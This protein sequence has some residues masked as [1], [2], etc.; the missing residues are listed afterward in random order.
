[1]KVFSVGARRA[2]VW[3]AVL[4]SAIL[5]IGSYRPAKAV[6]LEK[7]LGSWKGRGTAVFEG[8]KREAV[9]CNAYYT[10]G[11][12][13]LK[14]AVRCASTSYKIE[15]RSKLETN[16]SLVNGTWEERTFNAAGETTG[17]INDDRLWLTVVG[18]GLKA[19]MTVSYTGANQKVNIRTEGVHLQSVDI[20]LARN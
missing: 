4:S 16:G 2:S 14:L 20:D 10:G 5:V 6:Q 9:R 15:I 1:M 13:R 7:L 19:S 18:G 11:G 12:E 17:T 3:L 8:N